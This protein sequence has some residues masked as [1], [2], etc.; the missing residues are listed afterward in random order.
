MLKGEISEMQ[1]MIGNEFALLKQQ[2]HGEIGR[3]GNRG[4]RGK[5]KKSNAKWYDK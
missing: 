4:N 3:V 2:I 5:S 1:Q